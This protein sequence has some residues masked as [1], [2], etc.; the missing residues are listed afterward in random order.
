MDQRIRC[1]HCDPYADTEYCLCDKEQKREESL[2]ESI[3]EHCRTDWAVLLYRAHVA[4]SHCMEIRICE[5][6]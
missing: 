3:H 4:S 1:G 5:R 6:V 2:H